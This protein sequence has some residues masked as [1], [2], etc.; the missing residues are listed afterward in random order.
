MIRQTSN[1]ITI[2]RLYSVLGITA[3][4][5]ST[6]RVWG[7][8]PEMG[9]AVGLRDWL[10]GWIDQSQSSVAPPFSGTTLRT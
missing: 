3:N 7:V 2:P 5:K 9:G 8:I 10:I 4:S 1:K 6:P